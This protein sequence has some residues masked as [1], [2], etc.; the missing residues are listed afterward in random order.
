[1]D[2]TKF[3]SLINSRQLYFTRSDKFDDPFE[4]SLPRMNVEDRQSFFNSD[5]SQG[6][7]NIIGRFRKKLTEYIAIN[8]W[9]M[10][11]YE[12]AAMW[13]LYLKSD[14]GIAIQSTYSRLRQSLIDNEAIYLGMV[15]YID[16]ETE[17][18]INNINSYS[19]FAYKRLSFEH[20]KEVRAV[21]ERLP[22]GDMGIDM[23]QTTIEHGVK[24]KVD[25]ELLI[26]NIYIAPSAPSW[27]SDLVKAVVNKYE[28]NFKVVQ[29]D[30]N[31]KPIF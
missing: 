22:K 12:S 20:E 10:N 16:Y 17:L 26:D 31:R 21:I 25:L 28:Y 8:C 11:E 3:V 4:G 30:L 24:V 18:I 2:F 1:M 6:D 27:L 9:H 19:P 15:K 29:S 5:E 14:E 23:S 7:P 13:K